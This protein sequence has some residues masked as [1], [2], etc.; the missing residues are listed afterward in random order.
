MG[1][2]E[3]T[4]SHTLKLMLGPFTN[5]NARRKKSGK[6]SRMSRGSCATAPGHIEVS[7][8]QFGYGF[9]ANT[10]VAVTFVVARPRGCP[11]GKGWLI[12]PGNNMLTSRGASEATPAGALAPENAVPYVRSTG[13]VSHPELKSPSKSTPASRAL[14]GQ[15]L[16]SAG[17]TKSS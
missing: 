1:R 2:P 15:P 3:F 4:G 8:L 16:V 14:F 13:V 9:C 12:A 5:F 10:D 7:V 17:F 6:F 11:P